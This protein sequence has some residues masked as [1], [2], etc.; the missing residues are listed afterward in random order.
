MKNV[1]TSTS[2]IGVALIGET[3]RPEINCDNPEK[4]AINFSSRY[5]RGFFKKFPL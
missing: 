4:S 2:D 1:Y 3:P 5:D